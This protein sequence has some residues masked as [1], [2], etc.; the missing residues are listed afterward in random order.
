M[1]FDAYERR[2]ATMVRN[3]GLRRSRYLRLKRTKIHV[4]MVNLSCNVVRMTNILCGLDF[5]V[6]KI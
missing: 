4:I 6:L 1:L 3:N 5:A 2:F